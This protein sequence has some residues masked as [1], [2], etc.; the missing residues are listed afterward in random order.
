MESAKKL[1]RFSSCS[2]FYCLLYKFFSIPYTTLLILI[3]PKLRVDCQKPLVSGA[4]LT[5]S[6]RYGAGSAASK[7]ILGQTSGS[8]AARKRDKNQWLQVDLQEDN[9]KVTR[10]ATQGRSQNAQWVKKYKLQYS[11]D[12]ENFKYYKEQGQTTGKVIYLYIWR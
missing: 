1:C 7:A 6:S 3:D 4:K 12:G 5:A 11:D 9:F 8:W 10:V 2:S